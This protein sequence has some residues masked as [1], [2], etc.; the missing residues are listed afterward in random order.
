MLSNI[1]RRNLGF[2]FCRAAQ[3]VAAWL[4]E[5]GERMRKWRGNGEKMR[6]GR[7][8]GERMRKWREILYISSFS[9]YFLP[10]YPFPI[11]KIVSFCRK[12]LNTALLPGMSQKNYHTRHEKI[13]LGLGQGIRCEKALKVVPAWLVPSC[14]S[15]QWS[16]SIPKVFQRC[17]QCVP[18]AG[19]GGVKNLVNCWSSQIFKKT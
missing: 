12:K 5:N 6:K 14:H 17:T 11:S 1:F 10:L 4:Q 2:V 13:I 15:M 16:P 7:G 8:N 9:L 3:I 18:G 19:V